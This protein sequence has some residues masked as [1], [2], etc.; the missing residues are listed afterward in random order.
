MIRGVH[1]LIPGVAAAFLG[2]APVHAQTDDA[3]AGVP[4]PLKAT[5]TNTIRL[6]NGAVLHTTSAA[7]ANQRLVREIR[8]AHV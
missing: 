3:A 6:P 4:R 5:L 8:R 7:V 1:T 2:L